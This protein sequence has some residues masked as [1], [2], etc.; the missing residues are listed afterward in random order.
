MSYDLQLYREDN[1]MEPLSR[2]DINKLNDKFIVSHVYEDNGKITGFEVKYKDDQPEW[3]ED[4]FD[5]SWQGREP[6]D[7]RAYYQT[8]ISY[9][10]DHDM[11]Q[12]F[13]DLIE[14]VADELNLTIVNPQISGEDPETEKLRVRKEIDKDE[15]KKQERY[16]R[17]LNKSAKFIFDFQI[18]IRSWPEDAKS[19]KTLY[20]N[21]DQMYRGT[22]ERGATLHDKLK[23]IV[24]ILIGS[25]NYQ[26]VSFTDVPEWKAKEV[27]DNPL[28]RVVIEVPYFDPKSRSLKYDMSWE[29]LRDFVI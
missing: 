13:T 26:I 18:E 12:Y 28:L 10:A 7:D 27:T 9:A 8:Y 17:I 20:A 19:Y 25:D 11:W 1:K 6:D 14:D 4:G 3:V 23:E 2:E 22:V 16:D 24:P 5:I 21:G 15:R 29:D